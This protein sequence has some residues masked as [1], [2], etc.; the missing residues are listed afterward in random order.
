[1]ARKLGGAREAC[2]RRLLCYH[3]MAY[4]IRVVA[5]A[6]K[7]TGPLDFF[8]TSNMDAAGQIKIPIWLKSY[9]PETYGGLG[10]ATW[11]LDIHKARRFNEVRDALDCW[12][13]QSRRRPLRP[14]GLPN[15][16]LTTF[17]VEIESAPA[18]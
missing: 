10:K 17:T 2:R 14:D 4:V 5:L 16:P 7:V 12:K 1:M 13:Q 9:N 6:G 3:S 18:E 11:T 8:L 15:R